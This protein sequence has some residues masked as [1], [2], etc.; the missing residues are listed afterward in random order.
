MGTE[1]LFHKRKARAFKRSGPARE[2]YEKVLIVCEGSKTEPNYFR[3]LIDHYE[4]NTANVTVDGSCGSDPI[5]VVDHAIRL[6]REELRKNDKE[7]PYDRV[8]CVMDRDAHPKFDDAMD[9]LKAQK[10][11]GVFFPAVSVPCFEYW[12]LLHFTYT[13]A[14]FTAVGGNS[15][16]AAVLAELKTYW[17]EYGKANEN[18]FAHV[19]NQ[20]E[21]GKAGAVRALADARR[22]DSP[23]PSTTLHELVDYLQNIKGKKPE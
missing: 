13:R 14:A 8:Y 12:L 6:Y 10:P 7:G 5:S 4:I 23:N 11:A 18:V 22:T 15:A 17:P 20:I 2:P 19:L 21:F 16:G 3:G 1:N 9:K